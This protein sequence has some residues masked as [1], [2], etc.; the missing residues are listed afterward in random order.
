MDFGNSMG[1]RPFEQEVEILQT[2][3]GEATYESWI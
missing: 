3:G 2:I 1:P